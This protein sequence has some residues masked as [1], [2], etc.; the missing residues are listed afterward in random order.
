MFYVYGGEYVCYIFRMR[1]F[2]KVVAY[3]GVFA[4]P[5]LV[6]IVVD[7]FF[8]PYITGKNFAFRIIVEIAL[9]A[10]ILLALYE[11]HYRPRF[12]FILAAFATFIGVIFLADLFGVY[13]P[14]SLWSNFERM[15]GLVTLLH[16]FAY[17]LLT[18]SMLTTDKLWNRFFG[19]TLSVASLLV[20][21]AFM[22]LIGPAAENGG[23]WRVATTLG[24]S[25]YMAVYMLFH[26]FIAGL[27]LVRTGST[28]VRYVCGALIVLFVFFL[29]QTGTRG[30]VL[31]LL[32]GALVSSTYFALVA[33]EYPKLRMYALSLLTA[34]VI[35]VGIFIPLR[36]SSFIQSIPQLA[37]VADISLK[38]GETRLTIWRLALEGVKERPILGWGQENFNYV[39]NTY[40]NP[41]LYGQEAWFDRVHNVVLDWLVAGGIVGALAYFSIIGAA[42]YYVALAP[43]LKDRRKDKEQS[44]T[45]KKKQSSSPVT[46][47]VVERSLLFGLF[48]GYVVHNFFV[49]DNL[50]SYIFFA[51]VLA[52][53]HS[54]VATDLPRLREFTI[55]DSTITQMVAPLAGVLLLVVV[56]IVNVPG[57]LA[58][59]DILEALR[60]QNPTE[61]AVHFRQALSRGSFADQE[62]HE[63]M[64]QQTIAALQNDALSP[65]QKAQLFAETER[66]FQKQLEEKPGDVRLHFLFATFYRVT[67]DLEKAATQAG[68]ARA[69]SPQKQLIIFE[70][71]FVRLQADNID[72]AL[73]F[74]RDAYELAP[75]YDVA[76]EYY[77]VVALRA[78]ETERF[79]QMIATEEDW[80]GL[81]TND[82][83]I[84]ILY[85]G[86]EYE[87][88]K[89]LL[90]ARIKAR[91][92]DV[93]SYVNLAVIH[94]ESGDTA[95]GIQI[96]E[97]AV[98]AVPSFAEQGAQI[99]GELRRSLQE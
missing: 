60:A 17:F 86:K 96:I 19:T 36:D 22:Q 88:L 55:R 77:A 63:H 13:P 42:L 29:F 89:K 91:P 76:R 5:F 85:G 78:G 90:E 92:D 25:T 39:F 4:V 64:L 70:Q 23:G 51:A 9:A 30:A 62:I 72:E 65:E 99:I 56:Y 98:R 83:A 3:T 94:H 45:Y 32:G 53:I 18:A 46:L 80:Y 20:L 35:G 54:Y 2:L 84:Q 10:W 67:G 6:L 43:L 82:T 12:S 75:E 97:D 59:H 14:K 28:V 71:G 40:Y 38:A 31:G 16:V 24:N 27:L 8:F 21:L 37:R 79:S 58:A 93:Q 44:R 69:L 74:F 33:K 87:T 81:A 47:T 7:F 48:A 15:E 26:I 73:Q 52:F 66:E 49:F 95:Q 11:P 61:Q 1:D 41:S 68:L 57:I 34:L 50:I